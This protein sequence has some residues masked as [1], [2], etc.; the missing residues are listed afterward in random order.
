VTV[1]TVSDKVVRHCTGLSICAKMVSGRG[2]PW[3]FGRNWRTPFKDADFQSIIAGSAI[4]KKSNLHEPKVHYKLS[5]EPM[6][7]SVR[8]QLASKPPKA[9]SKSQSD[10]F[11]SK[12]WTI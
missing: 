9:G 3:K 7:N 8:C 6:M 1:N 4:A 12:I 2:P 5:S 11:P 10:R